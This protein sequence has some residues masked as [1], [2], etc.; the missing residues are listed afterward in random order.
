MD[1]HILTLVIYSGC[2]P[3]MKLVSDATKQMSQSFYV[4]AVVLLINSSLLTNQIALESH[5]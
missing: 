2:R 4:N 5:S 3:L 1:I